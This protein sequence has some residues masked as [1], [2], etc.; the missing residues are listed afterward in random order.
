MTRRERLRA[1]GWSF[2]L[3]FIACLIAGAATI[4]SVIEPEWIERVSGFSPDAGSGETEWLIP[5][6]AAVVA[7][8]AFAVTRL[9][10]RR[11]QP[12]S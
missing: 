9:Q 4:A 6:V 3:P 11:I 10:W 7:V 5:A 2:W 12:A 8:V 1:A